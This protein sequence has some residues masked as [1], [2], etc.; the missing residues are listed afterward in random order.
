M[1]RMR[2]AFLVA[3]FCSLGVVNDAICA[4]VDS[5]ANAQSAISLVAVTDSDASVAPS[6]KREPESLVSF[7]YL[8]LVFDDAKYVITEPARWDGDDWRDLAYITGGLAVTAAVLDKPIRDA[9]QRSRSAS[10]DRFFRRIERFGTK[11]YALP[12]LAGFYLVGS[13]ADDYEAKTVALDGLSSDVI[14]GVVTSTLKGVFGRA[15]PNTGH[16]PGHFQPLQGDTSFPSGHATGAFALASVIAAHYDSPWVDGTAYGIAGLVGLARI[17]LD[18]HWASDLVGGAL[19][20]G[21][22]G[23]RLVAFNRA[24]RDEHSA[25]LPTLGSDGAQLT[26]TWEF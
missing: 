11:Q 22:I 23:N 5:A 18:A 24:W 17:N 26:L 19:I 12:V 3:C 16:G 4:D 7:D 6:N 13:V 15:R 21:L 1:R 2:L 8:K 10:A 20:G 25:Y 9:A 14:A